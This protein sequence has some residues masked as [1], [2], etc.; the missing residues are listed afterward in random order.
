MITIVD[1]GMGNLGSIHNMLNRIGVESVIT[2]DRKQIQ[3]AKKLILPGVG[4]FDAAMLNIQERD[5]YDILEIK[6]CEDQIPILGICLRHA[7][8]H[9][10]E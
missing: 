9:L 2:G 6:A 4:S 3:D 1:Y 7:T 8:S 5:L 10:L